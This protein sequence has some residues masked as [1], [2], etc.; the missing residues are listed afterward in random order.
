MAYENVV[1]K[2]ATQVK[3]S[4]NSAFSFADKVSNIN[5]WNTVREPNFSKT[6]V[7]PSSFSSLSS[8]QYVKKK[9]KPSQLS[10]SFGWFEYVAFY[11]K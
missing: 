3:K 9:Y 7:A 4:V 5:N 10:N 8:I 11:F 2:E 1:F 6:A